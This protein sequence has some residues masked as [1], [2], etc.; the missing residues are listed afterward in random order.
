MRHRSEPFVEINPDD[1]RWLSLEAA[2]LAEVESAHRTVDQSARIAECQ[3]KGTLAAPIHWT[4]QRA[5]RARVDALVAANVDPVSGQPELKPTP[6]GFGRFAAAWYGFA[7][8]PGTRHGWRAEPAGQVAPA[9][10]L[11]RVRGL[12]AAARSFAAGRPHSSDRTNAFADGRGPG[13][14]SAHRPQM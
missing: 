8:S 6:V 14:L 2:H 10:W 1:A 12:V 5:S 9:D 7:V 3:Q 13:R 4:G 11:D